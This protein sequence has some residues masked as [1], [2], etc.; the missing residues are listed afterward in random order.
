MNYKLRTGSSAASAIGASRSPSISGPNQRG[1]TA[2]RRL[3][4]RLQPAHT[5]RRIRAPAASAGARGLP[6]AIRRA[7]SCARSSGASSNATAS[8]TPAKPT[9]CRS[10]RALLVLSAF[11]RSAQHAEN[12]RRSRLRRL[13]AVD[14]YIGGNEHAVL[15]L[16]YARFWHKV[17]F[18]V[19]V[20]K[21][22][23]PFQKLVHRA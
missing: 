4:G 19:G 9:P 7:R 16:L 1:S 13:D 12:L 14:L 17:L 6:S 18:D 8:G 5:A 22:P 11:P 10:G 3:P 21:H 23:E 2:G 15:H 20:V